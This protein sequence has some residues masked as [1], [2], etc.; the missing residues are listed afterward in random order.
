MTQAGERDPHRSFHPIV[1]DLRRDP[2]GRQLERGQASRG[3]S[4]YDVAAQTPSSVIAGP[5]GR[6]LA[7][8]M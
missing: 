7:P 8:P 3:P 6:A 1:L 4:P 5:P 2:S